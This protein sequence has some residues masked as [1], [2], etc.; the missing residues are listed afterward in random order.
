MGNFD[1][2]AAARNASDSGSKVWEPIRGTA[3]TFPLLDKSVNITEQMDE[4]NQYRLRFREFAS[5]CADKVRDE[6]N[7]QIVDFDS[8]FSYYPNIYSKYLGEVISL[9][10][11]A[12]VT[13]GVWSFSRDALIEKHTSAF[14]IGSDVFNTIMESVNLTSQKNASLVSSITSYIP[15]VIGFGIGK[16]AGKAVAK[17]AAFNLGRDIAESALVDMA[18]NV[19]PSQKQELFGRINP[20]NLILNIY[21][22]Y[23]RVF[24][25][26]IDTMNANGKKIW[27]PK[28]S[29][30]EQVK[31]IFSNLS[32]ANFPADKKLEAIV[33]ILSTNPY[34]K[35]YMRFIVAEYGDNEQTQAIREYFGYTDFDDP[36]QG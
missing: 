9:A 1:F 35:D 25:T 28:N 8:F 33:S 14:H 16:G 7:R 23:W 17:A 12:L 30:Q 21:T 6:Y 24:L 31:G 34:K 32:N 4:F 29:S 2:Y 5:E 10:L 36:R 18:K 15:H 3:H 19:S 27:F 13:E 22:D 26:L 20:Y 11:D